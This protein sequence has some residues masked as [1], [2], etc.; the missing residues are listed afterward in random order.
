[1]I[2]PTDPVA[3][4]DAMRYARSSPG[5]PAPGVAPAERRVAIVFGTYHRLPLLVRT[6]ESVRRYAGA[7]P[8]RLVVVDGGSTD[9]SR[10]W[11]QAQP[12]VELLEQMGP[13]TGAVA[14]FNLGYAW[15]VDAGYPYVAHLNDDLVVETGD[16]LARAV[17]HFGR[18]ARCGAVAYAHDQ[19]GPYRVDT[20]YGLPYMNF[21]LIRREAGMAVARAQGDPTGRTWWNPIYRTYGA[22]NEFAC[23]LHLLGWEIALGT[24]LRLHHDPADTARDA[25]RIAN[26]ADRPDA[27]DKMLFWHRWPSRES[28]LEHGPRLARVE[29]APS[30]TAPDPVRGARRRRMA[31]RPSKWWR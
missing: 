25:L 7:M 10:A 13:L 20:V 24:D 18:S 30:P 21:G 27:A 14:A 16:F 5:W 26:E 31:V 28:I 12:D 2:D 4:Y 23:W 29:S 3:A 22:D 15:A 6:V 9:G 11:L 8:Y 1:M 17:D 19:D